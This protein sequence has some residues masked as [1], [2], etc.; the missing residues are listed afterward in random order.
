MIR[1]TFPGSIRSVGSRG[2]KFTLV[3]P[4]LARDGHILL[5]SGMDLKDYKRNPVVLFSHMHEKP[6]ARCTSIAL[7]DG[8]I[9]GATE[10]PP[11]GTSAQAEEVCQLVKNS[12]VNAIDIDQAEPLDPKKGTR[13]GLRILRSTL[14]EASIVACPADTGANDYRAVSD[15][16]EINSCV[17]GNFRDPAPSPRSTQGTAARRFNRRDGPASEARVLS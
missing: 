5:P 7:V 6:V 3:T 14:L 11:E 17:R 16:V 2:F 10:F 4:Q 12:I 13:G 15:V 1:Q 8:E 9:R